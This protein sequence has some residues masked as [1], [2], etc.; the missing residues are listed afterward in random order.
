MVRAIRSSGLN[1]QD[2]CK[3]INL[4]DLAEH[5]DSVDAIRYVPDMLYIDQVK[6]VLQRFIEVCLRIRRFSAA[7]NLRKLTGLNSRDKRFVFN[8]SRIATSLP[9]TIYKQLPS[10]ANTTAIHIRYKLQ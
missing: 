2:T 6:H 5:H 9:T 7:I 1:N 8:S 4:V 3:D 10:P